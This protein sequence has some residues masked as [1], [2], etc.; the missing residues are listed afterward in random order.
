MAYVEV[1][2][3]GDDVHGGGCGRGTFNGANGCHLAAECKTGVGC[4]LA[5]GR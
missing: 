5:I 2:G 4:A 3:A 1:L